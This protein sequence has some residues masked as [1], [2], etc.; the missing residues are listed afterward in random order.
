MTKDQRKGLASVGVPILTTAGTFHFG[1]LMG[2]QY[3]RPTSVEAFLTLAVGS[4]Q[5]VAAFAL[6]RWAGQ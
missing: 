6:A 4:V 5:F 3:A 1:I 2:S